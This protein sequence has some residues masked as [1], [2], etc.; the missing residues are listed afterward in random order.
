[1]SAPMTPTNSDGSPWSPEQLYV[2]AQLQGAEPYVA[3][4]ASS[5]GTA[6]K[7]AKKPADDGPKKG[8]ALLLADY[9][10]TAFHLVNH[11][12]R[13]YAVPG[14]DCHSWWH[15][16][17]GIA[18]PFGAEFRRK[19]VYAASLLKD[20][21]NVIGREVADKV[22]LQLEALAFNGAMRG[23]SIGTGT[24]VETP[25]ALRFHHEADRVCIDLGRD[26]GKAVVITAAG[27]SVERGVGVVFRR[28]HTTKP[29]P[30]PEHGGQLA[31]LAS[32]LAL[33][34]SEEVFR[35]LVGWLVGLPFAASVRP[36]LLCVG[37]PGTGKS[38][39]LRLTTSIVEPSGV[40]ALG[41]SLGR[42]VDDDQVR[43]LHRAVPLWDNLTAVSGTASDEICRLITGTAREGRQLYSNDAIS[44]APIMR[45]LGLT[46]VGVPAGLRPDALDRLIVVDAPTIAQRVDDAELQTRFEDA[47]PRLLG[48]VCDAVSAVLRW[49]G[50]VAAPT[51]HRMASH[52]AV[53]AAVDKAVE[54]GEL[55]GCPRGLLE[56]YVA[57]HRRIVERTAAEDTF[58]AAVL[59]L[60]AQHKKW[61]GR[62]SELRTAAAAMTPWGESA[63]P[64]W[65]ATARAVPAV[66]AHLQN[67]LAALGVT[68]TTAPGRDHATVYTFAHAS[69]E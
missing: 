10:A 35:A 66:L 20:V 7:P 6:A 5:N 24:T 25:L 50:K 49:R 42:N 56:A 57:T 51:E 31:E 18:Q 67:G 45:P 16:P 9:F 13:A 54:A 14:R 37:P 38:T 46:A 15:G 34:P 30:V 43:A 47:H 53:L 36:G 40:D 65:P 32:L 58:G 48:A 68:W 8:P 52:A 1:M 69:P 63:A 41:S 28:S 61:T 44:T 23:D 11:A 55:A 64:G 26:D 29:L 60:V 17:P 4:P 27:W 39:R 3:P 62:A 19:I 21:P 59:A 33:E 12:G 2:L 22:M